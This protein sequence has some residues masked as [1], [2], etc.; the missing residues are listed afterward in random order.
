KPLYEKAVA[1]LSVTPRIEDEH[2]YQLLGERVMVFMMWGEEKI[3]GDL[4]SAYFN[5]ATDEDRG[6]CI[7]FVSRTLAQKELKP[8]ITEDMK[9]FAELRL[10]LISQESDTESYQK[11]LKRYGMWFGSQHLDLD[12]QMTFL[13]KLISVA[14]K[15][16][17]D[18][19]IFKFLEQ[20]FPSYS[21]RV[22]VCLEEILFNLNMDYWEIQH[23]REHITK[24][25]LDAIKHEN[26]EVRAKADEIRNQLVANNHTDYQSLI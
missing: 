21:K 6:H 1:E 26:E 13:E 3:D 7:W 20:A 4:I 18:D 19:E 17:G 14:F 15:I 16:D 2:Y 22:M 23:N 10:T 24:I 5:N 12:W 9:N 25:L 11:E 8:E